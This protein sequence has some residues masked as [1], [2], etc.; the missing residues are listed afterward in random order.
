MSRSYLLVEQRF[1]SLLAVGSGVHLEAGAGEN[2]G[3]EVAD[4]LV[5]VRHE[6][7][8]LADRDRRLRRVRDP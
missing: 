1:P 8:C 2:N 7:S 3:Y 4:A 5:I 6:D